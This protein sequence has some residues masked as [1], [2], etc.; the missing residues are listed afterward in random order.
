MIKSSC[1]NTLSTECNHKGR[2]SDIPDPEAGVDGLP[3]LAGAGFPPE[4]DQHRKQ[5]ART[6]QQNVLEKQK[7]S[8][9]PIA[10]ADAG[11]VPGAGAGDL[12][13]DP[14]V[15]GAG[16]SPM[17]GKKHSTCKVSKSC[18]ASLFSIQRWF[19]LTGGRGRR[20]S[21]RG[22]LVA[23]GGSRRRTGSGS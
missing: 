13:P 21:R 11:A 5:K 2:N 9:L 3:L 8:G 1:V 7:C 19:S 12:A 20:G 22:S 17:P 10:G 16:F 23:A 6:H 15:T 4:S 18:C 14:P